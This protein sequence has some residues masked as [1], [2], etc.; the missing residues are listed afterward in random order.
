MEKQ[1]KK[2][3]PER[4]LIKEKQ[5]RQ[6]ILKRLIRAFA[7][8]MSICL[9]LL[10]I[11][12]YIALPIVVN[13][14]VD[15]PGYA[16]PD[17]PM[18]DIY[19]ASDYNLHE[20]QMYLKTQDD[21]D[22]WVSEIYTEHP[23]AVMIYLTGILQPS[24]T[25]F[26][27]HSKLMQENGYASILVEVRGHGYSGGNK[28]ALGYEE[29]KDIK[30]VV[31]YIKNEEK[32]KDVPIILQGV[33]MGGA[34]AINAF[35]QINEIDGLI[36]MSAYS[37]FEDVI[38]DQMENYGVPEFVQIVEKPLI[39]SALKMIFGRDLV[40]KMKPIEQIQNAK[41]RPVLLIACSGD[42]GVP[43][44]NT[45][46][47]NEVNPNTEIWIRDSWEHFIV[48][49]CDFENVAQDE[50]YCNRILRFLKNNIIEND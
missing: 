33:S 3:Y 9:V 48:Q 8:T 21:L 24:V 38:I 22:I 23:K 35:G 47:L 20:K 4:F 37:S 34:V 16:T 13:R 2:A 42:T 49:N 18:Q 1:Y 12:P 46:R 39:R 11:T 25:Y 44:V 7:V 27:G 17:Y 26:Y 14:H 29:V 15:Y 45:Q 19:K 36:A 5:T 32:Y 41:G 10:L 40:E 28:I 43:A 6:S 50:E 30:A 31:A